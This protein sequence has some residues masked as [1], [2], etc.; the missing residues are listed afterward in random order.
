MR[1][2]SV[3][4]S[5]FVGSLSVV[6]SCVGSDPDSSSSSSSSSGGSSSGGSSSGGSSSGA[7]SSGAS[8]SGASSSSGSVGATCDGATLKEPGKA[9]VV[10]DLGCVAAPT[11][12][13]GKLNPTGEVAQADFAVVGVGDVT[14]DS[15]GLIIPAQGITLNTD[16]G[17]IINTGDSNAVIR[18]KNVD[19]AA[20]EVISQIGF[21]KVAGKVGIFQFKSLKVTGG[22]L[23]VLFK[24]SLP[25]ALV[26]QTTIT[27]ETGMQ[28]NACDTGGRITGGVGGQS[29]GVGASTNGSGAGG[30]AHGGINGTDTTGVS[31]HS[32][33]SGGG[34]FALG[35]TGAAGTSQAGVAVPGTVGGPVWGSQ[36]NFDPFLGGSGGGGPNG[37]S[38]GGAILLTAGEKI[39]IGGGTGKGGINAGGCAGSFSYSGNIPDS[40]TRGGGGSGGTILI[41]APVV[42]GGIKGVLAANGGSGT[43]P[44]SDGIGYSLYDGHFDDT[45]SNTDS[46]SPYKCA[47]ANGTGGFGNTPAGQPGSVAPG[48]GA[49]CA[50]TPGSRTFGGAGGGSVGRIRI[51]TKSGSVTTDAS[52]IY[53]PTPT[54]GATTFGTLPLE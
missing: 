53:S 17:E 50:S 10:C 41:E 28:V 30:G 20:Q 7:S 14:F 15:N 38:G 44:Y 39:T 6:F 23:P 52:F 42:V 3:S 47:G 49:D 51:L 12:H 4:L 16:T 26:A 34:Y 5:V 11:A 36:T 8:S 40:V 19:A 27:L 35:G 29:G 37:G 2:S 32:G 21:R 43:P 48:S 22:Y 33:G 24:G 18:A 31:T 54:T 13:C 45:A 9:D 46:P 25:V 1:A